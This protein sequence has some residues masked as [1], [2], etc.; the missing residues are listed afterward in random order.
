[1]PITGWEFPTPSRQRT[2]PIIQD[3]NVQRDWSINIHNA[4]ENDNNISLSVLM[5]QYMLQETQTPLFT[6]GLQLSAKF[7]IQQLYH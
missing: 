5:Q 2:G 1:M 6:L 7:F 4:D 3:F